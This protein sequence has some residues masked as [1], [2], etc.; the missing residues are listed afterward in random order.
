MTPAGVC[1]ESGCDGVDN[2]GGVRTNNVPICPITS[3]NNNGYITM[4]SGGLFVLKLGKKYA[5]HFCSYYRY[6]YDL[7]APE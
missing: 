5:H 4:G 2:Q 7:N 1:K 3:L 6:T